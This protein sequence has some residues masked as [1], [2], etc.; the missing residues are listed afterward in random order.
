M[1]VSWLT[2]SGG[3]SSGRPG[4]ADVYG[5]FIYMRTL[6][7]RARARGYSLIDIFILSS[8]IG[9]VSAFAIPRY[10]RVGN[11]AR[12]TQVLALNG[13]LREAAENA[14]AQYVASGG[15]L[16]A[17]TLQGKAVVLKNGYPDASA[18]GIRSVLADGEGFAATTSVDSVVFMKKGAV[19][20]EQCAVTYS[21][22]KPEASAT[23]PSLSSFVIKGC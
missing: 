20:P 22:A 21:V 16:R 23:A 2:R 3:R 15:A 1:R 18:L 7:S 13:I 6:H 19:L 10:T 12:A 14:H 9:V 4:L 5:M 17:A 11:E 8:L